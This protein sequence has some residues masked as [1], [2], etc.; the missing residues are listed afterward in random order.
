MIKFRSKLCRNYPENVSLSLSLAVPGARLFTNEINMAISKASRLTSKPL[1]LSGALRSE[2]EHWL[3]LKDWAGFLPWRLELHRQVKLYTDASSFAWSGVLNPDEIP[4]VAADYWP[5]NSFSSD[6]AVK[7]ALALANSLS[8]FKDRIANAR[9]DVFVD[10]T[11]LVHAWNKQ[12]SRSHA[13]SDALKAIFTV[14]LSTNSTLKLFHVP[15]VANI[16]DPA[17][18]SL[19][20]ADAKL[21]AD[22]W[23]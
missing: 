11:A 12:R 10:N 1:S 2:I 14:L 8:A 5:T 18:R 6:I 19:S 13:F 16:A 17:S 15:S 4:I 21:S 3:F 20:L 22:V 9:I 23:S 7:E